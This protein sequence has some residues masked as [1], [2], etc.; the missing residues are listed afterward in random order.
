M[1]KRLIAYFL[2]IL[3]ISISAQT[4]NLQDSIK[5]LSA[6]LVS[7][8][9]QIV[10]IYQIQKNEAQ[11]PFNSTQ[12]Q[13]ISDA[14]SHGSTLSPAS[15]NEP[16]MADIYHPELLK[17]KNQRTEEMGDT[18]QNKNLDIYNK[19]IYKMR[20]LKKKYQNH[21]YIKITGFDINIGIPP[22]VTISIEF[23]K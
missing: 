14:T 15:T 4:K 1:K 19:I 17:N 8:N 6:D 9:Q 20:E 12:T 5:D 18:Q 7:I 22:S 13:Q 23:K 16:L 21:P 11:S 2:I 10:K 3:P